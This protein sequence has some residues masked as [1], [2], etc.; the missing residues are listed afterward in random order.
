MQNQIDKPNLN[1]GVEA[2]LKQPSFGNFRGNNMSFPKNL[3]NSQP[4]PTTQSRP[5]ISYPLSMYP[6]PNDYDVQWGVGDLLFAKTDSNR[7]RHLYDMKLLR[8][9]MYQSAISK[10]MEEISAMTRRNQADTITGAP[11]LQTD[12]SEDLEKRLR[13]AKSVDYGFLAT[14]ESIEK[15]LD[16]CGI[17]FGETSP[18]VQVGNVELSNAVAFAGSA[19]NLSVMVDGDA[20]MANVFSNKIMPGQ[21]LYL[22]IKPQKP[23][24]QYANPRMHT[25]Q[26]SADIKDWHL[27]PDLVFYTTPGGGEP[28]YMSSM[29]ELY[30]CDPTK[31]PPLTDRGYIEWSYDSRKKTDINTER[32]QIGTLKQGILWHLG[33]AYN[34]EFPIV[35]VYDRNT[36]RPQQPLAFQDFSTMDKLQF[37]VCIEK[38]MANS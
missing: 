29:D 1:R 15:N 8:Y 12:T 19:K 25:F 31:Q 38:I 11:E 16:I 3:A 17:L 36:P 5:R 14:L 22:M 10:H 7:L 26:V 9:V 4:P 28:P 37:Q 34:E 27:I 35:D 13:K 2:G 20:Y 30:A 18:E 32:P 21:D 24:R 33:K 6:V 23:Q